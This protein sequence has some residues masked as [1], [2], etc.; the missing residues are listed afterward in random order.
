MTDTQ[1]EVFK[2]TTEQKIMIY[3][4]AAKM[5]KDKVDPVLLA[6][7][8]DL[9]LKRYSTFG[10]YMDYAGARDEPSRLA[11][12][13]ALEYDLQKPYIEPPNTKPSKF[14]KFMN[15]LLTLL[16]LRNLWRS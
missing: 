8:T 3:G 7:A 14:K 5:A 12:V 2:P 1:P 10:L 13:T 15:G 16:T 9:A 11:I 4:I 6:M